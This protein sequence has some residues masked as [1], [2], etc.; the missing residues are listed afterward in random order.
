MKN[1]FDQKIILDAVVSSATASKLALAGS[2]VGFGIVGVNPAQ[3]A[4]LN[5]GTG[6]SNPATT[7][8]FSEIPLA[9][10]TPLA[11]QYASLGVTFT[12]LLSAITPPLPYPNISYPAAK[13]YN[14]TNGTSVNP[15]LISF[16]QTQQQAAFS[17]VTNIGTST[18][19][20]L[21]NNIVVDTFSTATTFNS[22]NNFLWIYWSYI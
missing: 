7:I 6:I 22:P 4:S 13:N 2:I 5:N 8:T 11:N 15:F 9:E 10:N 16:I 20:A 19:A 12:G 21:L 3:A 17:M 14:I 1:I 18:F